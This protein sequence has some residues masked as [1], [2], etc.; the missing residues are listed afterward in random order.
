MAL[1]S[2][3]RN[4]KIEGGIVF[5]F[6]FRISQIFTQLLLILAV[7]RYF[8]PV[9]LGYFYVLNSYAG[10]SIFFELGFAN[11]I[12]Q[13]AAHEGAF[14]SKDSYLN[15]EYNFGKLSSLFRFTLKWYMIAAALFVVLIYSSS[16]YFFSGKPTAQVIDWHLPLL[17]LMLS[18][19]ISSFL[20]GVYSFLEGCL[21]I[22]EVAKLKF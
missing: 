11:V 7:S 1:A 17:V 16:F 19:A 3:I 21:F 13:H 20:N 6:I 4:L 14:I 12:M 5:N 18:I 9:E 10:M 15:P 8:T 22:K 2:K